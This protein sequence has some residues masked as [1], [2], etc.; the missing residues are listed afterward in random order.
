MIMIMMR[1]RVSSQ[2]DSES[3]SESE[4]I[5]FTDEVHHDHLRL[6]GPT[7]HGAKPG[8]GP[9]RARGLRVGPELEAAMKPEVKLNFEGTGSDGGLGNGRRRSRC[10]HSFG[11]LQSCSVISTSLSTAE[12]L[13]IISVTRTTLL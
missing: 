1:V 4:S 2:A 10:A 13:K 3:D 7:C 9:G 6:P 8:P 12:N 5:I 11:Q